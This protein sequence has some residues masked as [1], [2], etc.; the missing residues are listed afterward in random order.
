MCYYASGLDFNNWLQTPKAK[1]GNVL[2]SM[3]MGPV[4]LLCVTKKSAKSMS[5]LLY[6]PFYKRPGMES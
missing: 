1:P 3:S 2:E 4:I 5:L 6:R